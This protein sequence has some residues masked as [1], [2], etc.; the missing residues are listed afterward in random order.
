MITR[1]DAGASPGTGAAPSLPEPPDGAGDPVQTAGVV[2]GVVDACW[3]YEQ[4]LISVTKGAA[5][6][7]DA[8]A[9]ATLR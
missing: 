6:S 4:A 5:H 7:A 3:G 9:A 8:A 2:P 1:C